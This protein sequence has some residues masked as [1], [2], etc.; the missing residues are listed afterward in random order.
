MEV[1]SLR[2]CRPFLLHIRRPTVRPPTRREPINKY[3]AR[4]GRPGPLH[5]V[6]AMFCITDTMAGPIAGGA[7]SS[8]DA[9]EST[10]IPND[11][12]ARFCRNSMLRSIF[13]SM[14][15]RQLGAT[16]ELPVIHSLPAWSNDRIDLDAGQLR[17]EAN[18]QLHLEQD[19]ARPQ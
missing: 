9:A 13:T 11:S 3:D 7:P 10:R 2:R 15:N 17:R 18:R 19:R 14:S 1:P 4:K 5:S 16:Q 12:A 6:G 8:F